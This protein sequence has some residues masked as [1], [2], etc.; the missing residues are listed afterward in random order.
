MAADPKTVVRRFHDDLW[1]NP[2]PAAAETLL[3]KD[4]VWHHPVW[5]ERRGHQAALETIR[6]M[7]AAYPDLMVTVKHIVAEGD[8][9]ATH[10]SVTGTHRQPYRGVAPSEQRLTW[11]GANLSRVVDG[12]IVEL[13]SFP[14]ITTHGSPHEI[15]HRQR[16]HP[17]P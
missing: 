13:W 2:N 8:L 5:G 6:E 12:R 10:W 4:L 9:V 3:A 15:L 1:N 14:H 11:E 16:T 17:R 7:R